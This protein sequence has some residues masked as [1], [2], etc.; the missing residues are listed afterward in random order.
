MF[1][2]ISIGER[3][4]SRKFEG[5]KGTLTSFLHAEISLDAVIEALAGL[6]TIDFVTIPGQ[7]IIIDNHLEGKVA[8]DFK[9]EDLVFML[10]KYL[11]NEVSLSALS[12]WAAFIYLSGLYTL[13]EEMPDGCEP[14]DHPVWDILQRLMSPSIFHIVDR[15]SIEMLLTELGEDLS[16]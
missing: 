1:W 3:L 8:I 12:D 5:T 15:A 10:H 14:G 7:R 9:Q 2:I 16:L 11:S 6:I 13:T 4:W